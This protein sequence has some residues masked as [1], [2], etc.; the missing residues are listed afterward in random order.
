MILVGNPFLSFF[1]GY[2]QNWVFDSF[3]FV[4]LQ[5]SEAKLWYKPECTGSDSDGHVGPSPRAFHV[6]V[7]IDCHMF[8][9]GGRSGGQRS[10]L[11]FAYH[12]HSMFCVF[13]RVHWERVNLDYIHISAY[14]A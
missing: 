9:F 5:F 11:C 7:S 8:I 12:Y 1:V 14:H 10:C 6:A 4:L 2:D 3:C 13:V